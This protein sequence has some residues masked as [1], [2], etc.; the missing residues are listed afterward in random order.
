MRIAICFILSAVPIYMAWSQITGQDIKFFRI[1][2]GASGTSFFPLGGIIALAISNPPGS[3]ECTQNLACSVPGLIAV[4]QTSKG[5]ISNIEGLTTKQ[6]ESGLSQSDIALWAFQGEK[7]FQDKGVISKLRAIASIFQETV[8][9][10]VRADSNISSIMQLKGKKISIGEQNSDSYLT[11]KLILEAYNLTEP[12]ITL[13]YSNAKAGLDKLQSKEIDAIFIL[14]G[15]PLP[16]VNDYVQASS[17]KLLSIDG[18]QAEKFR[19]QYPFFSIDI[20]PGG[21]YRGI[22]NT[23]TLSIATLWLTSSDMPEDLVYQITK[24]LWYKITNKKIDENNPIGK[25][26]KIETALVGIPVPL[27]PGAARFYTELQKLAK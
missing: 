11:S 25:K 10:F 16:I 3:R 24:S 18:E 23:V 20:I 2:T 17:L 19:S 4:A 14:G 15:T 6:F 12:L 26:I 13:D 1:G 9:I 5:S 21:T 8:H 27:H 22:S 7:L